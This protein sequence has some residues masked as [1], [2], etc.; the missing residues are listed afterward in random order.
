MKEQLQGIM[1]AT[2]HKIAQAGDM[3]ALNEIRVAVL[4][5]KG[6]LT[7]L[8]RGLKDLPAELKAEVGKLANEVKSAI[9]TELESKAVHIRERDLQ[10]RLAAESI[11]VTLPGYPL[12]TGGQHPLT[13]TLDEIKAIFTSMGFSVAE[14]PEIESDYYCFEALNVSK[15]HPARD[16]QDTFYITEDVVLRT[17]TSPVQIREME[18]HVP[19]IP[20]KIIIPGKVYR[21]DDDATHSPMFSQVEGLLI[22]DN[23]RFSDLKGVLMEFARQLFGLD[24]KVRYRPSY[25]PFTEPSAEMDISCVACGG[26]GCR[27]CSHTGW[28]EILGAGMVHPNVLRNGGYD[29]ETVTGF[30]FGMGIERISMLK[31]GINDLRLFFDN[32][33]RF[34]AQF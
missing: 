18:K 12:K 24:L 7:G 8:L 32:D 14:G 27:V 21:K 5:R 34:L 26:S 30:A 4:G 3:N 25:F 1:S 10:T 33:L 13:R 19:R 31:Y 29:P 15:D 6:E 17:H 28:L 2:G 11:D 20:L 22:G 16:M 9:E 23:I